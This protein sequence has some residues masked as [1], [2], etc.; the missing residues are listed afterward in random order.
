MPVTTPMPRY[1]SHKKV[2]ALKI[3]GIEIREDGSAVIAPADKA[4]APFYTKPGWS[5]TFKGSEDD[6]GFYVVYD[7]GYASWSPSEA[8][9]SGYTRI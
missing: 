2:S 7:G 1:Q 8:F 6:P 5:T 3:A 9:E 4:Y